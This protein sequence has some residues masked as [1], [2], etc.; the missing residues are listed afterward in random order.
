MFDRLSRRGI[1][2][3][4]LLC[5]SFT[6]V[7]LADA[8]WTRAGTEACCYV[9]P[10]GDDGNPGAENAPYKTTTRAQDGV[11]RISGNMSGDL[12]VYLRGAT[13]LLTGTMQF[14]PKDGGTNGHDIVYKAYPG[15]TPVISGGVQVKGWTLDH[16]QIYKAT[17]DRNT[18][19]RTLFV[20][21]VRADMTA[22]TIQ[23]EGPR[24]T[25]TVRGTGPWAETPGST[26]DGIEFKSADH[27]TANGQR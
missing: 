16:D 26:S 7:V 4:A 27:Q 9:S 20:N 21:G 17:L 14:G 19:L 3:I 25:F 12:V 18:K 22:T 10:S 11:R 24:G 15:E 1:A 23:G 8:A 2:F 13:Y 5:L 6:R